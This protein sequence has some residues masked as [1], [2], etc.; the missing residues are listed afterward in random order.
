MESAPVGVEIEEDRK[1]S[2]ESKDYSALDN[3]PSPTVKKQLIGFTPS[4]RSI[5]KLIMQSN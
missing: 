5:T 4:I 1:K 2:E 3:K